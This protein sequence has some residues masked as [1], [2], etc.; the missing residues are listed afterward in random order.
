MSVYVVCVCVCVC[1]CLSVCDRLTDISYLHPVFNSLL[2]VHVTYG[3]G[4]V[5]SGGVA[6]VQLITGCAVAPALC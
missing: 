2:F 6:L 5:L 1:V 3:R 4:S